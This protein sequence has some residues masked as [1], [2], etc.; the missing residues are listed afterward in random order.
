MEFPPIVSAANIFLTLPESN[1]FACFFFCGIKEQG[2]SLIAVIIGCPVF[3][4]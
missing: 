3:L 1:D 4:P 2:L